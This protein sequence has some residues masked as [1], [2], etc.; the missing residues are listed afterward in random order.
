MKV[1]TLHLVKNIQPGGLQTRHKYSRE[2][3]R[4]LING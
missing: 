3:A 4:R 2:E 1:I